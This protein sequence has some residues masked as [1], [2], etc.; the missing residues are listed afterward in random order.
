MESHIERTVSNEDIAR[1]C[2]DSISSARA[3]IAR[4]RTSS[5]ATQDDVEVARAM[6]ESV[7]SIAESRTTP[8]PQPQPFTRPHVRAASMG[9]WGQF[10]DVAR[11][12]LRQAAFRGRVYRFGRIP[13]FRNEPLHPEFGDAILLPDDTVLRRAWNG[14]WARFH[15]SY[16]SSNGVFALEGTVLGW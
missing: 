5:R 1:R 9:T 13:L 15:H 11:E 4:A 8:A 12:G 10:G 6:T 3:Y 14:Q 16:H 7:S 2:R